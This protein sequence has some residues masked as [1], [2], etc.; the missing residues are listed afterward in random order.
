VKLNPSSC[1]AL[2]GFSGTD[3]SGTLESTTTRSPV[4][5]AHPTG[6]NS[7]WQSATS[8]TETSVTETSN[9]TTNAQNNV[10]LGAGDVFKF[11]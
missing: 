8:V 1:R 11:R 3:G 2:D 9:A 7:A 5:G 6:H 10:R 4:F